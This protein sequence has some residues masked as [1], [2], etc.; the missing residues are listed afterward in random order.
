MSVILA[1]TSAGTVFTGNSENPFRAKKEM[2]ALT[3]EWAIAMIFNAVSMTQSPMMCEWNQKIISCQQVLSLHH[4]KGR[5][6]VN[7]QV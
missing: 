6:W 4:P 7:I 3:T 1:V 5:F 2:L